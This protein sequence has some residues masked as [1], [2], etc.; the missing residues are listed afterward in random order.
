M[1]EDSA[2]SFGDMRRVYESV[3][4]PSRLPNNF[5]RG[6]QDW[7]CQVDGKMFKVNG[8]LYA[9]QNGLTNVCA[10]VALRSAAARFHAA[11]DMSYREMN[12]LLGVDHVK[13]KTSGLTYQQ[14][15]AVL[16]AAG[17]S[18]F[19]PITRSRAQIRHRSKSIC[20]AALSPVIP[21]S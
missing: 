3:T 14:M 5:V 12:R 21:R 20:T 6:G 4:R 2:P 19:Q 16:E 13:V 15:Q 8:Y 18:V 9:Q 1:K 17:R 10:H 7:P 11:G